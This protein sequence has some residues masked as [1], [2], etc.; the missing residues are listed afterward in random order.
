MHIR[1]FLLLGLLALLI[2]AEASSQFPGGGMSG[3]SRGG[4]SD[5][6]KLFEMMSGGKDVITRDTLPNPF[7]GG[8]FDRFAQQM[9]VTD[10]RITREQFNAYLQQKAAEKA[11][12][13]GEAPPGAGGGFRSSGKEGGGGPPPWAG[14][15]KGGDGNE[16][17]S[18]EMADRF[19]DG[20]FRRA[21]ANG[22]GLLNYDEMSE[23][24]RTEL[25]KW[26]VN[27]DG[28]IDAGEYKA[29]FKAVVEQRLSERG[30]SSSGM[31]GGSAPDDKP[32]E[33]DEPKPVVYRAG[34]L[35]KEL[36][37]WFK[38]ADGDADGQ[39]T[40]YEWRTSGKALDEFQKMDRN[41]DGFLTIAEV[42][43]YTVGKNNLNGVAVASASSSAESKP[44]TAPTA[45]ESKSGER[46][47]FGGFGRPSFGGGSS[48][49]SGSSDKGGFSRPSFGGKGR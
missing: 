25:D 36:P 20:M 1:F 33:E 45:S 35:P 47:S 5:P 39:I 7:L 6:S 29:Y 26:D 46:P 49:S 4:L 22:D 40:M 48:G 11:A 19:A 3:G 8:M 30:G 12:G 37:S 10:G 18:G 2:P 43:Y 13:G 24:L 42:L 23:S 28:F 44:A 9:G 15:F 34:K 41:G 16:G 38:T 32:L 14:G 31:G 21:D 17:N 27:K